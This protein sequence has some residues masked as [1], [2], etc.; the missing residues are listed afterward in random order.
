MKEDSLA[1]PEA[2]RNLTESRLSERD[3][4]ESRLSRKD[5]TD[6]P[7][8]DRT[9]TGLQASER[10]STSV[11]NVPSTEEPEVGS[12]SSKGIWRQVWT[13]G[14]RNRWDNSEVERNLLEKN[15]DSK[16]GGHPSR[17]FQDWFD[18]EDNKGENDLDSNEPDE[19]EENQEWQKPIGMGSQEGHSKKH[20]KRRSK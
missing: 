11:S 6:E 7:S 5:S 8:M 9:W 20:E 4:T 13:Q 12:E 16:S 19:P 17:Y 18:S 10:S 2:N 14:S 1:V 3:S 15:S